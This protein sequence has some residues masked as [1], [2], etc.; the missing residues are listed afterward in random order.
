M[1][2]EDSTVIVQLVDNNIFQ[3]FKELHPFSVVRKNPRMEHV[4]IGEN[5]VP[6]C[7]DGLACILRR[8][9]VI[10]EKPHL[11]GKLLDGLIQ[12]GLLILG[13]GFCGEQIYGS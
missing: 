10:C 12:L 11:F 6:S 7:P 4:R 13:E 9:S 8:V 5:N 1:A 3:V 2:S